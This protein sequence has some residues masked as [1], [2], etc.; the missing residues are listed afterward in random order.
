[1]KSKVSLTRFNNDQATPAIFGNTSKNIQINEVKKNC[2]WSN[3]FKKMPCKRLPEI[4]NNLQ[5]T[6]RQLFLQLPLLLFI[7]QDAYALNIRAWSNP[8]PL[9][10]HTLITWQC[11]V[12]S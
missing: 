11:P 1:V 5:D 2:L 12:S 7:T 3:T 4:S 9:L 6:K 10:D 8:K